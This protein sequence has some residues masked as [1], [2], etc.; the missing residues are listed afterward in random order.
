[1]SKLASAFCGKKVFMAF[2]VCGD[3]DMEST[4]KAVLAAIAGGADMIELN[5]P[6]S[7]PTAGDSVIQEANIRALAQGTTTDRVFDLIRRLRK[8]TEVPVLLSGYANVIFSY[9]ADRFL[10]TCAD[11]GVDGIIVPDLP[12]EEREEF[13][14]QCE[15]YGVDLIYMLAV[16]SGSR[17]TVIA[18]E[19]KGFLYIMACPGD[20]EQ[21][22]TS[23]MDQVR[24]C[25]DIPC[26]VCLNGTEDSRF[27]PV[28]AKTDG[29][30]MDAPFVELAARY[31][32]DAYKYI[33]GF[34]SYV[35]K[36]LADC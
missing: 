20:R 28:A 21:E 25:S 4:E 13:L 10:K 7:D 19:A 33:G 11:I 24:S 2:F 8:E 36:L 23:I 34:A 17:V 27:V 9:G 1:M 22:L 16:T 35:K 31:G 14:P 12:F 29:I 30:V 15:K 3:P 26:V 18:Q 5:I 6:F 32:K